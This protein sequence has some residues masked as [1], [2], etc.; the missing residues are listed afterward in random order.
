MHILYFITC[1]C[2]RLLGTNFTK[3]KI[4]NIIVSYVLSIA[5]TM[6][7]WLVKYCNKLLTWWW[8]GETV[9]ERV[10]CVSFWTCAY[11]CVVDDTTLCPCSTRPRTW[12]TTLLSQTSQITSTFRTD[13]TLWSTVGCS[14]QKI[15]QT[16]ASW[17]IP[18][19]TPLVLIISQI[20]VQHITYLPYSQQ[21][22]TGSYTKPDKPP[23]DRQF[24]LF[25]PTR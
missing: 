5:D 14:A 25:I 6:S 3:K 23:A 12:V 16:R 11:G 24:T 7:V 9:G 10:T 2:V 1:F 8:S 15:R 17:S 4:Y 21:H 19:S 22:L 20:N 18:N 13:D